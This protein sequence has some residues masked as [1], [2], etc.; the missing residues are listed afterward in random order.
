MLSEEQ[1][2]SRSSSVHA[3]AADKVVVYLDWWNDCHRHHCDNQFNCRC[4][5]Y[6]TNDRECID[7]S[8]LCDG[9]PDCRGGEDEV[10][11]VCSD[12]EF[13][14]NVCERDDECDDG[15][16]WNQCINESRVDDGRSD[17]FDGDCRNKNDELQ[18]VRYLKI[19]KIFNINNYKSSCFRSLPS[20]QIFKEFASELEQVVCNEFVSTLRLNSVF[21]EF[22]ETFSKHRELNL[23]TFPQ[24]FP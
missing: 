17:S 11:C 16:P 14:C 4:G 5:V 7:L 24:H 6:W 1:K 13:Q 2:C 18:S 23:E 19:I 8:W 10:D 9:I 22:L 15:I 21:N 3:A 12:D 20:S